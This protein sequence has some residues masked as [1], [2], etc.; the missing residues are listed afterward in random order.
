MG[1]NFGLYSVGKLSRVVCEHL[2]TIGIP[3]SATEKCS[4]IFVDR[5]LDLVAPLQSMDKC[6]ADQLFKSFHSLNKGSSDVRVPLNEIVLKHV[7]T[8]ACLASCSGDENCRNILRKT[9]TA[10]QKEIQNATYRQLIDICSK[11]N[12]PLPE[13]SSRPSFENVCKVLSTLE[14][15]R[16]VLRK[17][18]FHFYCRCCLDNFGEFSK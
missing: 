7:K 3:K 10:K 5:T 2:A 9:F 11:E 1:L 6:F 13:K 17:H 14:A 15:N 4:V 8:P 12:V 16:N 18:L